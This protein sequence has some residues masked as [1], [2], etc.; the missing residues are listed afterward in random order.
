[1]ITILSPC[2]Q[3]Q[4]P[5]A[6]AMLRDKKVEAREKKKEKKKKKTQSP[7]SAEAAI[8]KKI[9]TCKKR[10]QIPRPF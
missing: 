8:L 4:T 5:K 9:H 2:T 10:T 7:K 1:M 3:N 6:P